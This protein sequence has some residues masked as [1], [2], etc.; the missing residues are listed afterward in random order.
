MKIL[1]TRDFGDAME[2]QPI[3]VLSNFLEAIDKLFNH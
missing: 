2:R 3:D 1:L